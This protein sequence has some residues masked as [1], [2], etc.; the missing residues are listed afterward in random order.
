MELLVSLDIELDEAWDRQAP[1]PPFG[2]EELDGGPRLVAKVASGAR[3]QHEIGEGSAHV[4]H[5]TPG[6]V[7]RTPA[8]SGPG[9]PVGYD[10]L[11]PP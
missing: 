1:G 11:T 8:G 10:L 4:R 3:V 9:G 7:G 6:D 2:E 5:R